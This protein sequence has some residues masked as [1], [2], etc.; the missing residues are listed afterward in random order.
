LEALVKDTE[1]LHLRRVDI[2]SW[3]SP[4]ARQHRIAR[5]PYLQM[6]EGGRLIADGTDAVLGRA[7]PRPQAPKR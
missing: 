7:R 5:L 4:V 2:D 3:Q 6:Y 1:D